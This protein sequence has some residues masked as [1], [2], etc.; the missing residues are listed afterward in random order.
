[1]MDGT[2][3]AAL[4]REHHEIDR[5]IETFLSRRADEAF[6]VQSL[7]DALEALRRHIYLEEELVFPALRDAGMVAPVFVMLREH[8]EMWRTLDELE[9][10]LSADRTGPASALCTELVS[11]LEAHNAKE[12]TIL[13]SQADAVLPATTSADLRVFL[14]SGQ[15]PEGW[16]CQRARS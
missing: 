11:Q 6:S 16:R 10:E 15:T 8:G 9:A 3:A 12:E 14:D 13:Y 1:M 4:E 5:G 2:L 7:T